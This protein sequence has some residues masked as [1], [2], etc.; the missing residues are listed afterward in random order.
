MAALKTAAD[1]RSCRRTLRAAPDFRM[2]VTFV[3][4]D[5]FRHLLCVVVMT[6][7]PRVVMLLWVCRRVV[8]V[9]L[10]SLRL[11]VSWMVNLVL[12]VRVVVRLVCAVLSV[13]WV[14]VS[15]RRD[16]LSVLLVVASLVARA[17]IRF[18]V[19]VTPVRS[20]VRWLDSLLVEVLS[21][22]FMMR[23]RSRV[24]VVRFWVRSVCW[25]LAE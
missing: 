8:W 9:V 24:L 12:T 25:W 7:V 16:V 14:L 1:Y 2:I 19:V 22:V 4:L 6:R 15:R 13:A 18:C 17:L 20:L 21:V 5:W 3:S 11:A 10:S 23:V